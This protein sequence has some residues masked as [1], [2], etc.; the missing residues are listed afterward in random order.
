MSSALPPSSPPVPESSPPGSPVGARREE[1]PFGSLGRA[2]LL[3]LSQTSNP[4]LYR[5]AQTCLGSLSPYCLLPLPPLRAQRLVLGLGDGVLN[6]LP[7]G[8]QV[9]ST[10][11]PVVSHDLLLADPLKVLGAHVRDGTPGVIARFRGPSMAIHKNTL[12]LVGILP[13]FE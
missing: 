5:A 9:L 2:E 3:R 7:T 12:F 13:K 6:T 10:F 11:G 4:E 8:A 1:D